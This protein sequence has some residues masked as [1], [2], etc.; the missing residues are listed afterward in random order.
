MEV[1]VIGAGGFVGSA[2]V[3]QLRT[4][5][6]SPEEIRRENFGRHSGKT[7]DLVVDAA[8]NSRKYLADREPWKDFELTVVHK[9]A[10]LEKYP[11]RFHLHVSS[12]DVYADLTRPETTRED[13][14]AG[15][16]AS[17]YGFH[18]WLAEEM[19]RFHA[20]HH[21]ICRLAGMVGPGLKKNPVHDVLHGTPLQI[22]PESRYQF[23]STD[24]AARLCLDLWQGGADR[25]AY[26][27]CGK[28]LITPTEIARQAGRSLTAGPPSAPR[29]VDVDFR[30]LEKKAKVPAT[31]EAIATF[32]AG[33]KSV[34]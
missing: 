7:W 5:G 33:Q 6:L 18:K 4:R 9:A 34:Q 29:I 24:D 32:L 22:H 23:L 27:V 28:G 21:L 3:R 17:C 31:A 1:A 14:P 30:K 12:V 2:F 25:E 8:G 15:Q 11:S 26:N 19:V 10:V 20:G 16:G 13:A